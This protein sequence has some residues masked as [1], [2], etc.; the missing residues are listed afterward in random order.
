MTLEPLVAVRKSDE[1]AEGSMIHE[2]IARTLIHRFKAR[3]PE[4]LSEFSFNDGATNFNVQWLVDFAIREVRDAV[5]SDWT[6]LVEES[7]AYEF[8][9]FILSGHIDCAA[10]SPDGTEAI[11]FDWKTGYVPVDVAD[12]NEQ[13]LGYIILLKRAYPK[14]RKITFKI[15]QPRNDEDE[16]YPRVSFV[17]IEFP[18]GDETIVSNFE[19]RMTAALDQPMELSTGKHCRFCP[20]SLQC[21]AQ[22]LELER[23]KATLTPEDIAKVKAEPDDGLLGDWILSSKALGESFDKAKELLCERLDAKGYVDASSGVRIT[24][25]FQGGSY[26]FPHPYEF[27]E[28]LCGLLPNPQQRAKALSFSVTRT[29]DQIAEVMGIPKSGKKAPV[30]AETVFDAA[31]RPLVVQGQRRKFI[32]T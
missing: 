9:R 22:L 3:G 11:G 15:V 29:K 2:E 23:M 24:Q 25:V 6:L 26:S 12:L 8:G 7:Y 5:P 21:K 19:A 16:G 27:Y 10:F 20:A 1:G 4:A 14:L 28:K 30:T 32:F 17:T 31:L 18:E 13:V